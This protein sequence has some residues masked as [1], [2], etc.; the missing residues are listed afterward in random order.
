V[1]NGE[2]TKVLAIYPQVAKNNHEI[3]GLTA[4][5]SLLLRHETVPKMG[6]GACK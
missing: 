5:K 6:N 1:W 3:S 4:Q 2:E